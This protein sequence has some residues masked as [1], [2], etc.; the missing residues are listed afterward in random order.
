M[1]VAVTM[2]RDCVSTFVNITLLVVYEGDIG[3]DT[4]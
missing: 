4:F 1:V 3:D 2:V